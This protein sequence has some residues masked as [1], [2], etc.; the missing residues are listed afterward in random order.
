MT[1]I[2]LKEKHWELGRHYESFVD[3]RW[4]PNYVLSAESLEIF[5]RVESN[6]RKSCSDEEIKLAEPLFSGKVM[7][8]LT[9]KMIYE[10]MAE[11]WSE[12]H[13]WWAPIADTL[14]RVMWPLPHYDC[15]GKPRNRVYV[16][17]LIKIMRACH[18][19]FP[20]ALLSYT[21]LSHEE[22]RKYLDRWERS[23]ER[24]FKNDNQRTT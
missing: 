2:R 21:G 9:I 5:I 24:Y 11:W 16:R 7:Y 20:E 13:G 19:S 22:K 14:R 6:G 8:E 3:R 18:Q 17:A 23:N 10:E 15:Y 4:H 1:K 12:N